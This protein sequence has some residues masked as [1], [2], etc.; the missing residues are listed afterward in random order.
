LNPN[1]HRRNP[2][3]AAVTTRL[4]GFKLGPALRLMLSSE[5]WS[6]YANE[7]LRF[8]YF[9]S[10]LARAAFWTGISFKPLCTP[11]NNTWHSTMIQVTVSCAIRCLS[12][13][14]TITIENAY[15]RFPATFQFSLISWLFPKFLCTHS[16]EWTRADQRSGKGE[17]GANIYNLPITDSCSDFQH[18][19][20][21]VTCL[22][23]E[24]TWFSVR[25]N[26]SRP[27][28]GRGWARH[29][30]IYHG[31]RMDLRALQGIASAVSGFKQPL[32]FLIWLK[33]GWLPTG[34]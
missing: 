9:L 5:S 19:K 3:L 22:K 31:L 16:V 7:I 32:K 6:S 11:L 24:S 26:P 27:K 2:T 10:W 18:I 4:S 30:N 17:P 15:F 25:A 8:L 1:S 34:K 12:A 29:K 21:F 13:W 28:V 20:P 23:Q 33:R 14:M